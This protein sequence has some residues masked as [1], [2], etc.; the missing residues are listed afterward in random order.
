MV[1]L[2]TCSQSQ[3][4]FISSTDWAFIICFTLY[5]RYNLFLLILLS[6]VQTLWSQRTKNYYISQGCYNVPSDRRGMELEDFH[7][8]YEAH[9]GST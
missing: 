4:V 9:S 1:F 6:L 2:I 5:D 3:S 8:E 7:Q